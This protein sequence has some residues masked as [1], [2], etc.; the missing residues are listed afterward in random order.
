MS[1]EED[2]R[3][4]RVQIEGHNFWQQIE[5]KIQKTGFLTARFVEAHNPQAAELIAIQMIKDDARLSAKVLNE[6]DNPPILL[7]EELEEVE[8]LQANIG[9]VFYPEDE[10]VH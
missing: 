8:E 10:S 7:I 3:K 6:P 4:Y 5:G 9:Y 1:N 2:K